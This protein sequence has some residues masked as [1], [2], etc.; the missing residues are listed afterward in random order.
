MRLNCVSQFAGID[1]FIA[2]QGKNTQSKGD[3]G[4]HW[5]SCTRLGYSTVIEEIMDQSRDGHA[6]YCCEYRQGGHPEVGELAG[7]ELSLDLQS[8]Q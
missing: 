3:I 7:I 4:R 2:Q 5:N 8:D 6:T 1:H